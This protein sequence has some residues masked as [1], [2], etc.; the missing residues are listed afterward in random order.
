MPQRRLLQEGRTGLSVRDKTF[1]PLRPRADPVRCRRG[2]SY[3]RNSDGCRG[4][5]LL[6][7]TLRCAPVA[8]ASPSV[9]YNRPIACP[10]SLP[11]PPPDAPLPML[12][13]P[14]HVVHFLA[15]STRASSP[16]DADPSDL[17]EWSLFRT[18]PIRTRCVACPASRAALHCTTR[19]MPFHPPNHL[20][21]ARRIC[22]VVGGVC[23]LLVLILM[24]AAEGSSYPKLDSEA[25]TFACLC[26]APGQLPGETERRAESPS[27]RRAA[28]AKRNMYNSFHLYILGTPPH[29]YAPP[30]YT[31]SPP[32]PRSQLRR[33]HGS[34]RGAVRVARL[35]VHGRQSLL[36]CAVFLSHR[37]H[38][39]LPGRQLLRLRWPRL[40]PR[41]LHR[42]RHG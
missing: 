27:G 31:V 2:R 1:C 19:P 16:R 8:F 10:A 35:G 7:C 30:P 20:P 13:V 3:D 18:L 6:F 5:P 36:V 23:G 9:N 34:G 42:A 4:A 22:V 11:R 39:A 24:A 28:L 29:T 26:N 40:L 38:G 14:P 37:M 12:N 41:V 33:P 21:G 25:E 17:T 32:L 15:D